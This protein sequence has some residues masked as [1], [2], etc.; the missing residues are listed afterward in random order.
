[1]AIK[2]FLDKRVMKRNF[3]NLE[4]LKQRHPNVPNTVTASF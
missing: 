3:G 2:G 4:E 1:M